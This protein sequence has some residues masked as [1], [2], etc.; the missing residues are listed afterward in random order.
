M[1]S[2]AEAAQ[3]NGFE[4][5]GLFASAVVA[6]NLA[7][8]STPTLNF[9]SGGYLATRAL[10]NVIYINNNTQAAANTRSVVFVAGIGMIF[11]LFI[12]SGNALKSRAANL[13]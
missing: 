8:L 5:V 13:L 2:R 9:L 3:M 1:I 12:K 11:T 10:Y 6:G 7:G 4:N